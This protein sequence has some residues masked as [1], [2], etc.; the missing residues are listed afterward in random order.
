MHN[1]RVASKNFDLRVVVIGDK[2]M[3]ERRICRNDDFR[4]SGSGQFEYV[5]I[6]ED[7]LDI[8]FNT[9]S[10]LKM[11]SVAFDFIFENNEPL[12]VEMSYGFGVHGISHCPG[13]YTADKKWHAIP[14]PDFYG[15]MIDNL[16]PNE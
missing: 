6:R 10:K 7:I 14:S 9:A 8:A 16:M 1:I 12:I 15:W 13:Y 2:A 11:Q 3:G 5:P 4:A